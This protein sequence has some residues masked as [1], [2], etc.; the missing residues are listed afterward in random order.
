[1]AV[2]ESGVA[3]GYAKHPAPSIAKARQTPSGYSGKGGLEYSFC[4]AGF[5]SGFPCIH[6]IIAHLSFWNI[7]PKLQGHDRRLSAGVEK[8]GT[9]CIRSALRVS[10]P[11]PLYPTWL[12]YALLLD[13][14]PKHQGHDRWCPASR[15]G[16]SYIRSGGAVFW[17]AFLSLS[18]SVSY[19]LRSVLAPLPQSARS[20]YP[21][22][23]LLYIS[24][25]TIHQPC[26]PPNNPPSRQ[27]H[28]PLN[29]P[30][31]TSSQT[32]A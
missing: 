13:I 5:P 18:A 16:D 25:P 21:V 28:P 14:R 32:Q 26:P 1:M 6:L 31:L 24:R 20:R 8:G 4:S 27:Q 9:S 29:N 17:S 11:L 7:G 15:E 19:I 22:P 12:S 10:G 3:P 30:N 2:G 23:R